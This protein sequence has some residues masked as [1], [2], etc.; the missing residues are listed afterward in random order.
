MCSS[1]NVSREQLKEE[2]R[3]ARALEASQGP[4]K[5]EAEAENI[6]IEPLFERPRKVSPAPHDQF[7][8]RVNVLLGPYD[9]VQPSIQKNQARDLIGVKHRNSINSVS[10]VSS[11]KTVSEK[12][13][14]A[15]PQKKL[16]VKNVDGKL[17][18]VKPDGRTQRESHGK[19]EQ[20]PHGLPH[21]AQNRE[22][23]EQKRSSERDQR[24]SEKDS[25]PSVEELAKHTKQSADLTRKNNSKHVRQPSAD[26]EKDGR[27]GHRRSSDRDNPRQKSSERDGSVPRQG[28][29]SVERD[30]KRQ[31]R[32]SVSSS[33]GERRSTSVDR[34]QGTSRKEHSEQ[35]LSAQKPLHRDGN[36]FAR[37]KN[38]TLDLK[39]RSKSDY[40]NEKDS[41]KTPFGKEVDSEKLSAECHRTESSSSV[42]SHSSVCN[43]A[44]PSASLNVKR[45][46]DIKKDHVQAEKA[47]SMQPPNGI[48]VN[49]AFVKDATSKL[50]DAQ[51]NLPK[52]KISN[53]SNRLPGEHGVRLE[54]ILKEMKNIHPPLTGIHTPRKEEGLKFPFSKDVAQAT[55]TLYTNRKPVTLA[56][57][58][59]K[60]KKS[61][62]D[63]QL[64]LNDLAV[65]SDSDS[66]HDHDHQVFPKKQDSEHKSG[67]RPTARSRSHSSSSDSSENGSD[68]SSDSNSESGSSSDEAEEVPETQQREEEDKDEEGKEI[69]NGAWG[70][71]HYLDQIKE[72]NSSLSPCAK[73]TA[74]ATPAPPQQPVT[75]PDNDGLDFDSWK[76]SWKHIGIPDEVPPLIQRIEDRKEEAWDRSRHS[77]FSTDDEDPHGHHSDKEDGCHLAVAN[78]NGQNVSPSV[79]TEITKNGGIKLTIGR[80]NETNSKRQRTNSASEMSISRSPKISQKSAKLHKQ[81]SQPCLTHNSTS[82]LVRKE[83]KVE[84]LHKGGQ[85]MK[86]CSTIKEDKESISVSV[87]KSS[88]RTNKNLKYKSKAYLSSDSSDDEDNVDVVKVP[89]SHTS[90]KSQMPKPQAPPLAHSRSDS[91]DR[92]K[93]SSKSRKEKTPVRPSDRPEVK[94]ERTFKTEPV[95]ALGGVHV[96]VSE[97]LNAISGDNLTLLSPIPNTESFSPK[98]KFSFETCSRDDR[99]E[100]WT[101]PKLRKES[102]QSESQYQNSHLPKRKLSNEDRYDS[103]TKRLMSYISY[104]IEGHP[105]IKVHLNRSLIQRIPKIRLASTSSMW[106]GMV[107]DVDDSVFMQQGNL[108]NSSYANFPGRGVQHQHSYMCEDGELSASAS[109]EDGQ[110]SDSSSDS[111][112]GLQPAPGFPG[113]I[114]PGHSVELVRH[115]TTDTSH[116]DDEENDGNLMHN[117]TA[118]EEEDDGEIVDGG[119]L[120]DNLQD[121]ASPPGGKIPFQVQKE[122]LSVQKKILA[123]VFGDLSVPSQKIPKRKLEEVRQ[124]DVKR[125]KQLH[126]RNPPNV[127]DRESV[128]HEDDREWDRKHHRSRE[129]RNSGSSTSSRLSSR[130]ERDTKR[131]SKYDRDHD[132]YRDLDRDRDHRDYDRDY[133]VLDR[134]SKPFER[135]VRDWDAPSQPRHDSQ[136]SGAYSSGGGGRNAMDH[137]G[138]ITGK[139]DRRA[140]SNLA[141]TRLEEEKQEA[142]DHYLHEAKKLKHQADNLSDRLTK[143][144]TYVEAVLSFIQC[145]NAME[146]DPMSDN[147]KIFTMYND[148]LKLLRDI[149]KYHPHSDSEVGDKERKLS[150]LSLRIQS[151]LCLK[152]FKLKKNE[153]SKL[154]QAIEEHKKTSQSKTPAPPSPYQVQWNKSLGTPSPMSPTP[155]PASVGSVEPGNCSGDSF[156]PRMHNGHMN[157][158]SNSA[159]SSPASV[160][161]PLRIHSVT[162]QYITTLNHLHQCHDIWDQA[163]IQSCDHKGFF[164]ELDYHCNHLTLHSSILHLVK[165]VRL[166]L[167]RLKDT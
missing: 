133:E 161:I 72:T 66:D 93:K 107:G 33:S 149:C 25:K 104:D 129:R 62:G 16:D 141:D 126:S 41:S 86:I 123:N 54:D 63:D 79:H 82:N 34:Q 8:Q 9:V 157:Y 10:S 23:H 37:L 138:A 132:K 92:S 159:V 20:K 110:K 165:Y 2:A 30:T 148:T 88:G 81:I 55:K 128:S 47:K 155:S 122:K 105:S 60:E 151:L 125:Q 26:R 167:H 5:K 160:S 4:I 103:S 134:S 21:P 87:P 75:E 52:L 130:S 120:G 48:M 142:A 99:N 51:K 53:E 28:H 27:N 83:P 112:H 57:H 15:H 44:I 116:D 90:H 40:T 147:S 144:L 64:L 96:D 115:E 24:S 111:D 98:R 42:S 31:D 35:Q 158:S 106:P 124:D 154:R 156:M 137:W 164:T 39:S 84:S 12:P 36:I 6:R 78:S 166:G 97:M 18:G 114:M 85:S 121:T 73:Q 117:E 3:L 70:L 43:D 13:N 19:P 1:G 46:P 146:R 50:K 71:K 109:P 14:G 94:S 67:K 162:Q 100:S 101:E 38:D 89:V 7:A 139:V 58:P 153:A 76:D 91:K 163:D 45:E 49:G 102:C 118:A 113:Y 150:L 59:V 61:T 80:M 65:S 140:Y 68:S 56:D 32:T 74:V 143:S 145:G 127:T 119:D 131:F 108:R 22:R 152:L 77:L 29:G 69:E 136:T 17:S 11:V 95:P 135:R